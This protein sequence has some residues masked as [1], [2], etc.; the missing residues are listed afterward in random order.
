VFVFLRKS[1]SFEL[2]G[3]INFDFAVCVQIFNLVLDTRIELKMV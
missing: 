2:V 1:L 3:H